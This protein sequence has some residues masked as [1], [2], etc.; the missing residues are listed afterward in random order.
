VL[1]S[2]YE[3]QESESNCSCS[4]RARNSG[5]QRHIKMNKSGPRQLTQELHRVT[6]MDVDTT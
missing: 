6:L 3:E 1:G 5:S 2:N 4:F